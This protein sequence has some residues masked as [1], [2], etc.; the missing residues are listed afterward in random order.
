MMKAKMNL[1]SKERSKRPQR[2]AKMIRKR[3]TKIMSRK[4]RKKVIRRGIIRR[5]N[6]R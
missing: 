3:R 5:R 6:I 1:L 2:R 4:R